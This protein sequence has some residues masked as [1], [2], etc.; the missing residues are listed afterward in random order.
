M[1]RSKAGHAVSNLLLLLL[2][3]GLYI[4]TAQPQAISVSAP[5][6]RG[7]AQDAVALQFAVSW[8]AAALPA[9]LD[10]LQA[11]G[12]QATFAVSGGW[13]AGNPELARRIAAE[14]HEL[15]TM[16]YAPEEDGRL[17][18]VEKDLEASVT[19]IEQAAGVKPNLY[20]SGTRSATVSARAAKKLGL[21][22]VLC[23]VDLMCARGSAADIINRV[24]DT[25]IPGS[26]M[27]LQPTQAAAEALEGVLGALRQKGIEPTTTGRVL[28]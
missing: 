10:T 21:T 25:P 24:S 6:Y 17:S 5:I 4:G 15:A 22:Q 3:A 1:Q 28:G 27:L 23:T 7:S 12:A 14:G 11:Q 19:A 16:G 13:A 20:Y 18:W 2:I 8:N 9:I 26:I